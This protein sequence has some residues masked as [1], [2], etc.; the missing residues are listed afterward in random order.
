ML[1]DEGDT[2]YLVPRATDDLLLVD[3]GCC[4]ENVITSVRESDKHPHLCLAT[5]LPFMHRTPVFVMFL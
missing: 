5:F 1:F 2:A 3:I 4:V